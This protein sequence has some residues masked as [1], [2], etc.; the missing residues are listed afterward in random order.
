MRWRRFGLGFFVAVSAGATGLLFR[1]TP[2]ER[3]VVSVKQVLPLPTQSGIVP[4]RPNER[5]RF[6]YQIRNAGRSAI[7][8]LQ[9]DET[10]RCRVKSNFPEK[11]GPNETTIVQVELGAPRFGK[12]QRTVI[13]FAGVEKT[14]IARLQAA[15]EVEAE[16]PSLLSKLETIVSTRVHGDDEP[17]KFS[18]TALERLGESPWLAGIEVVSGE[19]KA[20]LDTQHIGTRQE[21]GEGLCIRTYLIQLDPGELPAG[22]HR[23][24]LRLLASSGNQGLPNVSVPVEL[25]ILGPVEVIPKQVTFRPSANGALS[26]LDVTVINRTNK[27]FDI[28]ADGFDSSL[29]SVTPTPAVDTGRACRLRLSLLRPLAQDEPA[30]MT[31]QVRLKDIGDCVLP[32]TVVRND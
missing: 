2:M 4:A 30:T 21:A 27:P 18:V 11:L 5:V 26:S 32:V 9:T 10:C 12:L 1:G 28:S 8:G 25:K 23:G 6:V 14:P 13:L 3:P 20:E 7:E 19:F 31:V 22:I 16:V 29:L 15:L 17:T 24:C